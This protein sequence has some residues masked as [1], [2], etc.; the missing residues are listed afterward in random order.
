MTEAQATLTPE[1]VFQALTAFWLSA[2]VKAG[3]ELGLFAALAEGP[4]DAA[5]L[6]AR[7]ASPARSTAMLADALVGTGFLVK[8]NGRY[9]LT[10]VADTFLDPRKPSYLGSMTHIVSGPEQWASFA[11]LGSAVRKGG[12]VMEQ[13]HLTPDDPF[14]HTFAQSSL[15]MAMGQGQQVAELLAAKGVAVTKAL[16]IAAGTG[17]YG[18]SLGMRFPEATVAFA[19][20]PGVLDF[21]RQ[22]A[23]RFGLGDR[24][25]FRPGDIF[26]SDWGSGYDLILLPN[27]YHHFDEADCM[28]LSRR[29]RE[30][31][32]PGGAAVVVE[33]VPD[34][35]RE[36]AA[37]PLLFALVMLTHTPKGTTYSEADFRRF[38]GAA[39]FSRFE[40]APLGGPQ[41]A[42]VAW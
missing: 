8:S 6:G 31:L 15:A 35:A 30:A 20:W 21:T 19:D 32:K 9:A 22:N 41:T 5:T 7:I 13:G 4:L 36:T 11:D 33:F 42:I 26:S 40:S 24:A 18:C 39:G 1:P 12:C 17:G 2:A 29:V 37:M 16:D 28:R 14:W 27:I 38:L 3:I 23:Q 34:D 25:E 10:P